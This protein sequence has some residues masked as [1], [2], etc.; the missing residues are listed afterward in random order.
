MLALPSCMHLPD[1]CITTIVNTNIQ[2]K[3]QIL[4]IYLHTLTYDIELHK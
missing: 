4:Y 3:T 1:S 2:I